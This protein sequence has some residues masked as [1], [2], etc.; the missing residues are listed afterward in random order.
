MVV[1]RGKIKLHEYDGDGTLDDLEVYFKGLNLDL[2]RLEKRVIR[3]STKYYENIMQHCFEANIL[4]PDYVTQRSNVCKAILRCCNE[5]ASDLKSV[6]SRFS[7][8]SEDSTDGLTTVFKKQ[9]VADL[10]N[11]VG[12]CGSVH[13]KNFSLKE[14]SMCVKEMNKCTVCDGTLTIEPVS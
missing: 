9:K 2:S 10:Y 3:Q 12:A 8:P 14:A 7:E 4:I 11:V 13:C 5:Y 1:V 6:R